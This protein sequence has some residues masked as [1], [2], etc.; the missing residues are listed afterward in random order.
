MKNLIELYGK[1]ETQI[2][3]IASNM[4]LTCYSNEQVTKVTKIDIQET[5]QW[6]DKITDENRECYR[7]VFVVTIVNVR[8]MNNFKK[9]KTR[10]VR[11]YNHYSGEEGPCESLT[12]RRETAAA[13]NHPRGSDPLRL[14]IAPS[15]VYPIRT[16]S[17]TTHYPRGS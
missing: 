11:I 7:D 15:D 8:T 14:T 16:M 9:A 2:E 10:K 1:T 3:T 12:K 4:V 6:G 5:S 13:W 17:S